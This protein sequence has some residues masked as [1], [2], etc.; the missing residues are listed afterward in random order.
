MSDS[1]RRLG[2]KQVADTLVVID[3]QTRFFDKECDEYQECIKNTAHQIALAKRRGDYIL[4]VEFEN[5]HYKTYSKKTS[6]DS[7]S[8]PQLMK[9][10]NGYDKVYHVFKE[11]QDGGLQV[12]N[13]L[14]KFKIPRGRLRVCGVYAGWCV[15]KTVITLASKLKFSK[16]RLVKN[17]IASC[18]N[19]DEPNSKD[20]AFAN[21]CFFNNVQ[22]IG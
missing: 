7:P 14:N 6:T 10:L 1:S 16:I 3:M 11:D 13:I 12:I 9:L 19:Y 2:N 21:M 4:M 18:F 15:Q 8:L 20:D 17:A 5:G 22:V